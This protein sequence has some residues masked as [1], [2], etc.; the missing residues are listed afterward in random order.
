MYIDENIF[1]A[2]PGR[3]CTPTKRARDGA[4]GEGGDEI[5]PKLTHFGCVP[6]PWQPQQRSPQHECHRRLLKRWREYFNDA[7]DQV[8][9]AVGPGP[10]KNRV[11]TL[12]LKA[13]ASRL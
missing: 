5:L 4:G 11:I 3:S 7:L 1:H 9:D 13:N 6:K 8:E 2:A 10:S 12:R